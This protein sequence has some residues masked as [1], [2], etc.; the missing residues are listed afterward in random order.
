MTDEERAALIRRGNE[1]YNRGDI[2]DALKIFLA[3]NYGDG[4]I[5][6]GDYYYF[7]KGD[8]ISGVKLYYRANHRKMVERFAE[9]AASVI[10]L[11]LEEDR[12]LAEKPSEPVVI[13]AEEAERVVREW[14]PAVIKAEDII[15]G[16]DK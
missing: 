3:T 10:H 12:A 4:I 11:L 16:K 1:L 9:E 5:R 14:N 15:A 8:R 2:T 7:E 13:S 6:V